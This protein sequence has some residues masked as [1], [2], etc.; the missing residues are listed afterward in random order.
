MIDSDDV[1]PTNFKLLFFNNRLY[2]RFWRWRWRRRPVLCLMRQK[3]EWNAEDIYI[4]GVEQPLLF[5]KFIGD[6]PESSA[7]NL[8]S[9]QLAGEGAAP[10]AEP[11]N[12]SHCP[13]IPPFG[14]H[15]NGNYFLNRFA[16]LP[17]LPDGIDLLA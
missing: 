7:Y 14:K 2:L 13:G 5:V 6:P 8:F 3:S 17:D 9:E 16:G 4:L 11:H 1:R 15:S 12:V 10:H